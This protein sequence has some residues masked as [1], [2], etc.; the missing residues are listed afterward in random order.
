MCLTAL[1]CAAFGSF[2]AVSCG[3]SGQAPNP[4][5]QKYDS[6]MV[7]Y[8]DRSTD[9]DS[10]STYLSLIAES[11]DSI[12]VQEGHVFHSNAT[13]G[14]GPTLSR[15]Q[16]RE[17]L[18]VFKETLSEQR[19]RIEDLEQRLKTSTGKTSSLQTIVAS[20]K[21]QLAAKDAEIERISQELSNTNRSFAELKQQYSTLHQT[22]TEQAQTIA[23]QEE[24][25]KAQDEMLNVGYIKIGSKSEL[26]KLGLLT[27]G[28]IFKKGTVSYSN[29]DES[30]FDKVD[31]RSVSELPIPGKKAKILTPAPA[32]SYELRTGSE[33]SV[34]VITSPE[35]FWSVSNYLIIQSN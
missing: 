28:N 14:E 26:K 3:D 16:I 27:S 13:P 25:V 9:Y 12:S 34:L 22:S 17:N 23:F 18:R 31:I 33:G 5:E 15:K 1:V 8:T 30:V 7:L 10:L 32:D 6:L 2:F 29:I 11:L 19:K 20:L 4:W 24:V 21:E 35:R